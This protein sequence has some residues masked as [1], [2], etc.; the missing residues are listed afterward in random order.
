MKKL[1]VCVFAAILVGC[2]S[3]P[4]Q[5]EPSGSLLPVY[6]LQHELNERPMWRNDSDLSMK[7]SKTT[8]NTKKGVGSRGRGNE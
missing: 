5:T 4:K 7:D 6:E 3:P 2:S 1:S 8:K